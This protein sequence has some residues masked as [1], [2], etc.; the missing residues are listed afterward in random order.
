MKV[1]ESKIESKSLI[2][3]SANMEVQS[4][5]EGNENV[6]CIDQIMRENAVEN[7]VMHF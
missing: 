3:T 1:F 2:D 4:D 5:Y 6:D 7:R